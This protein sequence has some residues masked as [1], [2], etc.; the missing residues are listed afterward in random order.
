M[1]AGAARM[2]GGRRNGPVS[3]RARVLVGLAAAVIA[4]AAVGGWLGWR[5]AGETGRG[6]GGAGPSFVGSAACVSCHP[7]P[8]AKWKA[9]QHAVA[10][11]EA[12][13][14]HVLGDFRDGGFT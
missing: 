10:M 4:L 1:L 9:S 2:A 3:A 7:E 8:F 14:R 13:P 11:Q 6:G 5:D 12:G